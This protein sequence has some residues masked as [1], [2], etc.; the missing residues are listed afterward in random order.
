MC[1]LAKKRNCP[2]CKKYSTFHP[3]LPLSFTPLLHPSFLVSFPLSFFPFL[4]SL[5]PFLL[6]TD[7]LTRSLHTSR[8]GT[9]EEKIYD[10]QV[11]KE[12]LAMRVVDEKQIGRH[13][14]ASD[15]AELFTYTPTPPPPSEDE[16]PTYP[17]P[18]VS[19]ICWCMEMLPCVAVFVDM[20][21]YMA[22][23]SLIM[24]ILRTGQPL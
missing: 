24:D 21:M 15:L 8:Q 3:K 6:S 4:P 18:E 14:T 9:M 11:T 7:I 22:V 16:R 13:Y 20:Y 12:S 19:M 1:D 5:F 2:T 10:R 17:T 23:E